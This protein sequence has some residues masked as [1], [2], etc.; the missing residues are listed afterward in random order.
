MV[1]SVSVLLFTQCKEDE[2]NN[3]NEKT[4]MVPVTFE[5]SFNDSK[6][7][8]T[9]ILPDGV[10]NWGND[11]DIER[12]YVGLGLTYHYYIYSEHKLMSVGELY[13][14]PGVYD[15]DKNKIIFS[16]ILPGRYIT[17]YEVCTFYYFGNN[18]IG[19]NGANVENIY[20][21]YQ[22]E[23]LMGKKIDFSKQTGDINDL[24]DFH[25]AVAKAIAIPYYDE[26]GDFGYK[27]EL[28]SL[29]NN[30]SIA[31]LDLEGETTLGGTATQLKSYTIVWDS[32]LEK[33]VEVFEY[34]EGGTY[35]VSGNPGQKSFVALLPT[36]E[37]VTL[38]CSKGHCEFGGGIKRNQIYVG[39]VGN[40]IDDS[41]P[42]PWE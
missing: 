40:T 31:M 26:N 23:M 13:E 21:Y 39:K 41:L 32:E 12:I 17:N 16:G 28:E 42:L 2:I 34:E 7:D 30:M 27:F 35:D 29:E 4:E 22:T 38:E 18:A 25:I 24:G 10:I 1:L 14:L 3:A 20:D 11:G 15:E 9:N 33:H 36:E 19:D 8:F 6:S 37:T 5:L